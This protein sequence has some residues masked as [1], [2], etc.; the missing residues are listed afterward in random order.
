MP[1]SRPVVA[2]LV[3]GALVVLPWWIGVA[4]GARAWD[5]GGFA[6]STGGSLRGWVLS[7]AVASLACWAVG[8]LLQRLGLRRLRAYLA[9]ALLLSVLPALLVGWSGFQPGQASEAALAATVVGV[10]GALAAL[11]AAAAWW[12]LVVRQRGA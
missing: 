6:G 3:A 7:L 1:P 2:A 11:P 5:D 4:A 8:S 9:V 12:W 10:T